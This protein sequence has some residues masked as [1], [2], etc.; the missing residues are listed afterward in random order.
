MDALFH[1]YSG[2]MGN[3]FNKVQ[4]FHINKTKF[5]LIGRI[6]SSFCLAA[7]VTFKWFAVALNISSVKSCM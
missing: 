2:K 3:S 6:L 4:T 1:I 7:M 5:E